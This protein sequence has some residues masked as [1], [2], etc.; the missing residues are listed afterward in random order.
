MS[1]IDKIVSNQLLEDDVSEKFQFEDEEEENIEEDK[2][3]VETNFI[4]G[5]QPP[6]PSRNKDLA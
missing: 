1:L 5:D 6:S 4:K 2:G 3:G